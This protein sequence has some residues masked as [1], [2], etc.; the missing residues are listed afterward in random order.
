MKSWKIG[1]FTG[2]RPNRLGGYS[3]CA[4]HTRVKGWLHRVIAESGVRI[5]LWGG[6]MGVDQ[7]GA[8]TALDLG[9][10]IRAYL[11]FPNM[12]QRWNYDTRKEFHALVKASTKSDPLSPVFSHQAYW[13]RDKAMVDDANLCLSVWD[14]APNGGTYLT[15]HYNLTQAKKPMYMYNPNTDE[16]MEYF[17]HE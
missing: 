13:V 9:C 6:A 7:W 8:R 17:L 4:M 12:E 16:S 11:P 3:P 15:T 10:E 5:W 1:M 14:G 2:H